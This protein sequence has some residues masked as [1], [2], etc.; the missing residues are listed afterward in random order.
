MKGKVIKKNLIEKNSLRQVNAKIEN[1]YL[2]RNLEDDDI[3]DTTLGNTNSNATINCGL[4]II[5]DR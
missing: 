1:I 3:D 2:F 5:N 4:I